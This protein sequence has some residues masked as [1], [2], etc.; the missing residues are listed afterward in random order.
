DLAKRSPTA[1]ILPLAVRILTRWSQDRR[2][3]PARRLELDRAVADV[4]GATGLLV[5]WEVTAPILPE[6]VPSH[7]PQEG[8]SDQPFPPTMAGVARWQTL[9]ATGTEA[10]LRVQ[11]DAGPKADSVRLGQTSL[12]LSEP[13]TVQFLASCNGKLR[14]WANAKLIYQ[15]SAIHPFQPDS[16]R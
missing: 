13:A 3:A 9:F 15:R 14:V 16:D 5:R 6:A 4:Q 11:D 8:L 12:T 1:E 10:R 2:L 7:I